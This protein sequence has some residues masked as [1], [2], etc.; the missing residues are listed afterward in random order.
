MQRETGLQKLL[1]A[2][3]LLRIMGS[4]SASVYANQVIAFVVPWLVLTRTGS[5]ANAGFVAFAMAAA[6]L[7][8]TLSGG[9]V[10]D[11]IGGR[12][13]SMIADSLSLVTAL[14]LALT[15]VFDYFSLWVVIVSQIIGV[16]F[17]APGAIAKN[18]TIPA[19]A[20]EGKV[21]IVRAMGLQ[22]T[23]QNMA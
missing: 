7:V 11:R 18:T 3:Q 14:L 15:L 13:V 22:Q 21:P 20:E 8:G 16:F 17:D 2:R 23:L 6:A 19:A 12:K 5:A 10:N 9:L 4:Q 1:G